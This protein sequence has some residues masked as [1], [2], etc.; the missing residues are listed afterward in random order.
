MIGLHSSALSR[1]LIAKEQGNFK[2]TSHRLRRH[3]KMGLAP[4]RTKSNI[5][6]GNITVLLI[7]TS[8]KLATR[9]SRSQYD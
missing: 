8:K 1:I 9:Y 7:F 4:I 3:K 5:S 6:K 2:N